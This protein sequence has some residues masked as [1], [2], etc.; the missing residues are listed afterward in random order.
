MI[1]LNKI[2]KNISTIIGLLIM[3]LSS[4]SYFFDFPQERN[5]IINAIEFSAGIVLVWLP[6]EKIA[7]DLWEILKSKLSGYKG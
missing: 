1:Y 7:L 4:S 3:I 2:K 6:I 5:E